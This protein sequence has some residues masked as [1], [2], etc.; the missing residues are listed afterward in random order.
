MRPYSKY[1]T[2]R[3]MSPKVLVMV[4]LGEVSRLVAELRETLDW[5]ESLSPRG[6][7]STKLGTPPSL[8]WMDALF[9]F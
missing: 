3:N 1:L 2:C 9:R 7:C 8:G 6:P 4:A 5:E